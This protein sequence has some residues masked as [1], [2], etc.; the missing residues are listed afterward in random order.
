MIQNLKHGAHRER[1]H[2]MN[3]PH[4]TWMGDSF[5]PSSSD[6]VLVCI[7]IYMHHRVDCSPEGLISLGMASFKEN[8]LCRTRAVIN[9]AD[10]ELVLYTDVDR[11][12]N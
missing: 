8:T 10:Y 11:R 6:F 1:Y 3:S 2:T 9:N 4:V 12:M 7:Y 5:I